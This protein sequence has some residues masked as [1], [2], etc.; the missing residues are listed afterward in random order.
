MKKSITFF[1]FIIIFATAIES[2]PQNQQPNQTVQAEGNK[3][4]NVALRFSIMNKK[5]WRFVDGLKKE[6]FSIYEDDVK[7]EI[8]EFRQ[9]EQ[10]LSVILLLD[11]SGSMRSHVETMKDAAQEVLQ[12]LNPKDLIALMT[13]REDTN[14]VADFT[15][16]KQIIKSKIDDLVC[17]RTTSLEQAFHFASQHMRK[18][19]SA[20]S[21][22]VIIAI[23]DDLTKEFDKSH[24][25]KEVLRELNESGSVVYGLI[26]PR[27]EIKES[28]FRRTE[29]KIV[30]ETYVKE[31][32]G[33]VLPLADKNA[34]AKISGILE[35]LQNQY[36]LAYVS[37]KMK[38]GGKP[39]KIKV[40]TSP[41]VEKRE[42]DVEMFTGPSLMNMQ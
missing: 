32:G 2:F 41:D 28:I 16:D 24:P 18:A 11:V 23:T 9:I 15:N 13:F 38:P 20:D 3:S 8:T 26:V 36:S 7:Q 17:A 27:P 5:T 22:H 6:N 29:I 42:G 21:R 12:H 40:K 4:G 34:R 30:S 25:I 39:P 1:L 31:T 19:A 33:R 14:L 10:P 35:N 37:T